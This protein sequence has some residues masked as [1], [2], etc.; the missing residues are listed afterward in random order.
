MIL[1]TLRL[2]LVAFVIAQ[3]GGAMGQVPPGKVPLDWVL[4]GK[5]SSGTMRAVIAPNAAVDI[6]TYGDYQRCL[7]S[8]PLNQ[9]LKK[10]SEAREKC[11]QVALNAAYRIPA[12]ATVDP[13]T[14]LRS[15]PSVKE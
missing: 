8:V 12:G 10:V 1:R 9:D 6:A 14:G 3:I 7:A 11:R 13:K 4:S 2:P 15:I 5:A